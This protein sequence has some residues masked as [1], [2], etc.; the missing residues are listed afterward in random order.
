MN[1]CIFC[2]LREDK[3]AVIYQNKECFVVLDKYPIEEGHMLVISNEHYEN[4]LDAPDNVVASVFKVSKKFAI[5]AR[6]A[7]GADSINIGSNIG[8]EAGQRVMHFHVH[9]IPRYKGKGRSFD[10][11]HNRELNP[12]KALELI[13][14]LKG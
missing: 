7:L 2:R 6:D 1:D 8:R 10:F 4:M 14:K 5:K 3:S 11:G 12:E 9:I 13:E